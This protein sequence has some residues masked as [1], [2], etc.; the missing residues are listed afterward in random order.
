[1]S[2]LPPVPSLAELSG[3]EPADIAVEDGRTRVTW[4]DLEERSLA[5]AHGLSVLGA[6]PGSHVAICVSNRVEFVEAV[7]GA[8]RAGCAAVCFFRSIPLVEFEMPAVEYWKWTVPVGA[9]EPRRLVVLYF[10]AR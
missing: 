9:G 1:M 6:E 2:A 7:L 8:W 3:R 5:V 10:A 4:A